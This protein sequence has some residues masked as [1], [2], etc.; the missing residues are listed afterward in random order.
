[1]NNNQKYDA[2]TVDFYSYRDL[3]IYQET[4]SINELQNTNIKEYNLSSKSFREV[5]SIIKADQTLDYN[6]STTNSINNINN[7]NILGSDKS[8]INYETKYIGD[9][10]QSNEN[11]PH[12]VI[13]EKNSIILK[14]SN[15]QYEIMP[16]T[17]LMEN[18]P[19]KNFQTLE[20][21]LHEIKPQIQPSS[22]EVLNPSINNV[23]K[24]YYKRKVN[25]ESSS[26]CCTVVNLCCNMISC[27]SSCCMRP[28]CSL[29]ALLGG[30]IFVG[31]ILATAILLG[32]FGVLPIPKEITRN[33]CNSSQKLNNQ[34]NN[35]DKKFHS[36]QLGKSKNIFNNSNITNSIFFNQSSTSTISYSFTTNKKMSIINIKNKIRSKIRIQ[37]KFKNKTITFLALQYDILLMPN[38]NS[39]NILK[40][41]N[42]TPNSPLS[43]NN[44]N[45]DIKINLVVKLYCNSSTN[46]I[47]F[48][49][50][51]FSNIDLSFDKINHMQIKKWNY[52]TI[53]NVLQIETTKNCSLANLYKLNIFLIYKNYGK[54]DD[55]KKLTDHNQDLQ[56]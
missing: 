16:T 30:L 37:N 38:S 48:K 23:T 14:K 20:Y 21:K 7:A 39:K 45:F 6:F 56:R 47:Y 2:N 5:Q 55:K 10:N 27:F 15:N 12:N 51:E 8:S 49:T 28:C 41:D 1:M 19:Q 33:I 32:M 36:D 54:I 26:E 34:F 53:S 40:V 31:F 4:S 17:N 44:L 13:E 46:L 50:R 43:S 25:I 35:F 3:N 22:H 24:N 42:N 52:D 18:N 9:L 11:Y 29:A